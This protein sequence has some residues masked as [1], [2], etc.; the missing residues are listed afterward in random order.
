MRN[1]NPVIVC[2]HVLLINVDQNK[3]GET[4]YLKKVRRK[5]HI[6]FDEMLSTRPL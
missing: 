3:T 2:T 6:D 4:L 1:K 5:E